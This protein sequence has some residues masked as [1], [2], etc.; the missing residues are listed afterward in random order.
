M[1]VRV[2]SE[3]FGVYKKGDIIKDMPDSTAM[4]CIKTGVVVAAD[5]TEATNV[6][7]ITK[8]KSKNA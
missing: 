5:S 2:I 3:L 1:D 8:N 6:K 4:A 7:P